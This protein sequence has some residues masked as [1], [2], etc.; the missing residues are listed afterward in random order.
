MS[1]TYTTF[2]SSLANMLV[3]PDYAADA[4]YQAVIPNIIDDAEQ[5]IYRDLDLLTTIIKDT[6]GK[7]T[8]SNR[9]FALPQHFITTEAINIFV[10]T[11]R[12]PL[13]PVS[14]EFLDAVYPED[15][16]WTIPSVPQYYA[17]FT[18][19]SILV[20]PCPDADYTMEVIGTIRP[21][22]LSA[23]NTTTY[24][25]LYLP[26][27]FL[28]A[29]CVYGAGYQQNFSAMGD[30]PRQALSWEAHYNTLLQSANIEENRKKYASQAWTS[31]QPAPLATP[32]RV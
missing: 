31:K 25:T 32:P 13:V 2:V 24:L 29:A 23:A 21:T 17:M 28:A 20:G 19:Q 12:W 9:A 14:K 22:P 1:L 11:H 6:T 3:I 8:P 26:D 15:A 18:D 16:P 30:N 5:R 27:L 7:L 4:N 10:E